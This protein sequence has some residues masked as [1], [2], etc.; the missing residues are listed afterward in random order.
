MTI[1]SSALAPSVVGKPQVRGFI[2]VNCHPD[3]C[4]ENV[5]R[6]IG[7]V[8]SRA[9][10]KAPA[11]RVLV[12]GSSTGFGLASRIVA[13]FGGGARTIGVFLERPAEIGRQGTGG[14][15]NSLAFAEAAGRDGLEAINING[16]AFSQEVKERTVREIK[17]KFKEVDLVVYSLAAPRRKHPLTGQLHNLA[18]KPIDR[19]FTAKTLDTDRE[20]VRE[21]TVE[22]AG[23]QE[24]EDTIAV[25]GGEDWEMWM[26]TLLTA[27][28]LAGGARTVAYSYIG[29]ELTWPLYKNGTIGRAK[30]DLARAAGRLND[31]LR[32]IGG[33]ANI[34]VNQAV[35]TQASAAIPVVGLYISLLLK[36]L[37]EKN[38]LEGCIEQIY[39]LFA[40]ELY[41]GR[42]P[43]L[44]AAGLIRMDDLE[45]RADVQRE[46]NELYARVTSENLKSVS[47]LS[48]YRA[49]FL[50]LFGFG[51]TG[52]GSRGDLLD[53]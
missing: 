9:P 24:I 22:A 16:D 15:Y 2:C 14:W 30:A 12:I 40:V 19:A 39:R 48:G 7:Y 42:A 41:G 4:R 11:E 20:M 46:V 43:R 50:R 37:K 31:M 8:K 13:A 18:L 49:E 34:S 45:M 51:P 17:E 10:L 3:G 28:V 25:M 33:S 29:P 36:V 35:V 52:T 38:I 26:T 21:I 44:D 53:L 32:P 23:Q 27:G 6:Q 1:D 5:E 47:D